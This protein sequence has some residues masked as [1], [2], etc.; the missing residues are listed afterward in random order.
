MSKKVIDVRGFACPIPIVKT[1]IALKKA[2]TGD[3]FEV[4]A[5]DEGFKND[6]VAWCESTHNTLQGITVDGEDITATIVKGC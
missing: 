1:S 5:T 6:I 2:S 4:T 3:V